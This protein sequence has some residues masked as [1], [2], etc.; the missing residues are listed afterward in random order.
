VAKIIFI[1]G[2][3]FSG[4]TLISLM[5]GSQPNAVF[6]GELKDYRRRLQSGTRGL[7]SFCSC[8]KSREACPFWSV[9]Q[10]R[11]GAE[12]DL[13]PAPGFS[14]RNVALA[15]KL[16]VGFG[17][18]RQTV[19]AHG[20]LIKAVC[21]VAGMQYPDA[22]Y[23]VDS[24][25]SLSSLDAISRMPGVEVSVIHLVRNGTAVAGSYKKRG[26]GALFGMATWSVGNIFM[27]LY[28]RKRKLRS[29]R[30]DYRSLCLGDE[31]TYRALNEFLGTH[32]SLRD[33][34]ADIRR[35]QYH[36]VSGNG[37]VRRSA[38][39]FQGIRYA[40]SPFDASRLEQWV[41]DMVVQPLNRS[42]G[43]TQGAGNPG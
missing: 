38:S 11:Y 39:D 1:A 26:S 2:S 23:V 17:L 12:D 16:L 3:S 19:T 18:R 21:D 5:L 14:L 43:V 6:A 10:E 36:F 24:S 28:V 20:S 31:A 37:R 41:A 7:G 25:K 15:I 33:A 22:A 42:L 27:R 4:S 40:E 29:I 9:V 34:A 30:V 32:L 35:T 13:N 8:G